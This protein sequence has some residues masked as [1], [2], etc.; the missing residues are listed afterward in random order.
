MR[1][2]NKDVEA[3]MNVQLTNSTEQSPFED[4]ETRRL[5]IVITRARH[6][7]LYPESDYSLNTKLSQ[8]FK[9]QAANR[10]S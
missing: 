4:N 2:M 5:I 8:N 9:F 10:L 6:S 3:V 1:I 7:V